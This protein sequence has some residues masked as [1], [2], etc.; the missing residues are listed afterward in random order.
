MKTI[1]EQVY[2]VIDG[3]RDY[4]DS[5]TLRNPNENQSEPPFSTGDYI[6]MLLYYA[7][8]LP[9]AWATNPGEAP[10]EVLMNMRKVAA[11]AVQ[12]QEW[13][14]TVS[15]EEEGSGVWG[16]RSDQERNN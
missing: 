6:T 7:N 14:G 2:K 8:Q 16:Q 1:R 5:K 3:E 13:W 11:I 4:Q 12:C 9:E 10:P 15:R